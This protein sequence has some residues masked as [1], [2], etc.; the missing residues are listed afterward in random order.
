MSR[1][2]REEGILPIVNTLH[3]LLKIY[4]NGLNHFHS[5]RMTDESNIIKHIY[6][7]ERGTPSSEK[8]PTAAFCRDNNE[9][10]AS[11]LSKIT[12]KHLKIFSKGIAAGSSP[13]LVHKIPF[14][15]QERN[16]PEKISN[17]RTVQYVPVAPFGL[18]WPLVVTKLFTQF[19]SA[20]F[21]GADQTKKNI[22][23]FHQWP[24]GSRIQKP[25]SQKGQKGP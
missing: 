2:I 5:Q 12:S 1:R 11:Y 22:Y 7:K 8:D 13:R 25:G 24:L 18:H 21:W 3:H 15:Q 10:T 20:N 9:P 19:F 17:V 23:I 14:F 4:Q 16:A 6:Q